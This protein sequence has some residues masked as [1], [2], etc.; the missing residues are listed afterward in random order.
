MRSVANEK[1]SVKQKDK[2]ADLPK[3]VLTVM[4]GE[5]YFDVNCQLS[6]EVWI[7]MY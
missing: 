5:S 1:Y 2:V 6:F 3:Y 4:A 7:E